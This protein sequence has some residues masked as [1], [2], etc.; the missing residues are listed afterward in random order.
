MVHAQQ[1]FVVMD[2]VSAVHVHL[3]ERVPRALSGVVYG[4]SCARFCCAS[5]AF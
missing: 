1:R 4:K 2:G 3:C 5:S